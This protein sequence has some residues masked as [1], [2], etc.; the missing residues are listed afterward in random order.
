MSTRDIDPQPAD[1]PGMEAGHF[2][3]D[4]CGYELA[5][6]PGEPAPACPHCGQGRFRRSSTGRAD[7]APSDPCASAAS[8]LA[9]V[10]AHRLEDVDQLFFYDGGALHSAPLAREW[11]YIGRSAE[12]DVRLDD[13]TVSRRHA[14]VH[15]HSAGVRILDH[16]SLNGFL[17]N[18]ERVLDSRELRDGDTIA[19]GRFCLCLVQ[20][21]NRAPTGELEGLRDHRSSP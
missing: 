9:E 12:A 8:W 20:A 11:T 14:V 17:V 18:G 2:Q 4:F 15:R 21:S 5:L 10:R 1:G 7:A 13:P 6:R 19:V 16:R 3:C